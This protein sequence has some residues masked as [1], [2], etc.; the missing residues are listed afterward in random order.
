M[1]YYKINFHSLIDVMTNS[2]SELFIITDTKIIDFFKTLLGENN[3]SFI[4]I[5]KFKDFANHN[6]LNEIKED[7]PSYY[8]E[9]YGNMNDEDLILECTVDSE[10]IYDDFPEL[11]KKLNFKSVY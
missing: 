6:D 2:S 1:I 5:T 11:L 8:Q 9:K 10:T 3:D 7:N 4:K